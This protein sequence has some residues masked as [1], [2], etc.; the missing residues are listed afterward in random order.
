MKFILKSF[1]G[2]LSVFIFNQNYTQASSRPEE[3][4]HGAWREISLCRF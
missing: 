4:Q 1:L 3:V 2:F